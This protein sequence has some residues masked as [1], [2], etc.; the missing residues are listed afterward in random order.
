MPRCGGGGGRGSTGPS[1]ESEYIQ[2][3]LII[4]SE[5]DFATVFKRFTKEK[6]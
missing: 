6:E 4:L 3:K 2:R 1:S 5:Q